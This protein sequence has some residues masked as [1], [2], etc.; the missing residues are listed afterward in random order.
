MPDPTADYWT[1]DDV[2]DYW[3][4]KPQTVRAYRARGRGELPKEDRMI[5]RTPVWRPKTIIEFQRPGSGY[6][7]DVHGPKGPQADAG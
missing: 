4:V 6:R 7:T 5:G 1:I 3:G 2:A